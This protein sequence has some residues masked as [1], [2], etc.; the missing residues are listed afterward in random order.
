MKSFLQAEGF[1]QP[2]D[3]Q[4]EPGRPAN[5]WVLEKEGKI[6]QLD[7][8]TKKKEKILEIDVATASEQGLLGLAFHPKFPAT[9]KIYLNSTLDDKDG[10]RTEI[11][12]LEWTGTTGEKTTQSSSKLKKLRTL[13]TVSQPYG[14][15]KAGQL[16]FGKDR[17][18]YVGFGDGGSAGDP[19]GN[20]QNDKSLLGK[21]ITLDIAQAEPK[22]EIFAKGLRNP[23]RFSFLSDGRLI[24][25]D[26]G[27]YSYEE[28]DIVEKGDNLGWNVREGKHCFK[29]PRKCAFE[30]LK[31]PVFEYD[32][33]QGISVTGGYEYLGSAIAELKGKYI[34]GDFGSGRIWAFD[35]KTFKET[36]LAK[37]P[38]A[39]STFGRDADGEIY[40]ADFGDGGIYKLEK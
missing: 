8:K 17:K 30:G 2:T 39:I 40:F 15:H 11:T 23:W 13:M 26:V 4:F 1:S 38:Y 12:E 34:F 19:H 9:P 10:R 32:R 21:M 25:G 31:D 24:V 33:S 20:S 37:T 18:L 22:P 36:L 6:W 28:I 35:T 7:I 16:V 29:P 5:I 14:N 3:I 27:Q